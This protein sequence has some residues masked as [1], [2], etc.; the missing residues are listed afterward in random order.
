M[1]LLLRLVKALRRR[2]RK[3]PSFSMSFRD[4]V[5]EGLDVQ[6]MTRNKMFTTLMF[7]LDLV[8][9]NYPAG[10]HILVQLDNLLQMHAS[11]SAELKR[12]ALLEK[13]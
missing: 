12:R 6:F 3:P 10:P 5:M 4:D 9:N 7:Q 2:W 13:K 11:F 8:S 1:R